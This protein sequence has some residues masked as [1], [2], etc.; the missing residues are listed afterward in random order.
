MLYK[1]DLLYMADM[2]QI[3][4]DWPSYLRSKGVFFVKREKKGIPDERIEG[5]EGEQFLDYLTCGDV[6]PNALGK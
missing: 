4:T 2:F 3:H 5:N 1:Y 6:H